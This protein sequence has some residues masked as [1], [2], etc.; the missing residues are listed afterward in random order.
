[1]EKKEN[2]KLYRSFYEIIHPSI[3]RKN[4]SEYKIVFREDITPVQ[5]FYPK[6]EIE[7]DSIII[8]I[9]GNIPYNGYY[10]ALALETNKIVILLEK[11]A[12]L[13]SEDYFNSISYIVDEARKNQINSKNISI[14]S[15]FNGSSI[16][17]KLESKL[18]SKK[19]SIIKKIL[20]SPVEMNLENCKF[21]NTLI[22]SNNE[23]IKANDEIG[24]N[25]IKESI[26]DFIND[27]L[28]PT[29]EGI[30]L[31]MVNFIE[32]SEV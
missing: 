9:Q 27:K 14:I 1:M 21:K 4:I 20:L 8:Y 26:Y 32:E 28:S 16:L 30:Y 18:N 23:T 7:L 19:Y 29:N 24:Y 31:K 13:E 22:L 10:D 11:D 17:L 2:C 12:N 6:K 3:S 25:L 15:D 5:I